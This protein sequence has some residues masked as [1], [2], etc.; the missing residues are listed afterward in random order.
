[1]DERVCLHGLHEL[2]DERVSDVGPDEF[3]SL[4]V[5]LGLLHVDAADV[6]DVVVRLE[7][8]R[9]PIAQMA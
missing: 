4:Q 8:L 1:M 3:R 5:D 2:E 9:Q 7:P 6:L